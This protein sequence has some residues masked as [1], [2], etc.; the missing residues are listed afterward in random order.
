MNL[1]KSLVSLV[2]LLRNMKPVV[3]L[4]KLK[5]LN[6]LQMLLVSEFT[7]LT[8]IYCAITEI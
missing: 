4:L 2:R 6:E 8:T 1:G 5:H 3:A 7:L